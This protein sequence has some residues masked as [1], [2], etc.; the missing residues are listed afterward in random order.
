MICP[1][2]W[3]RAA[4]FLLPLASPWYVDV[5]KPKSPQ[6]QFQ[7]PWPVASFDNALNKL[8]RKKLKSE[9]LNVPRCV[10][11]MYVGSRAGSHSP[12]YTPLASFAQ[13]I[14]N[15]FVALACVWGRGWGPF[16]LRIYL[17]ERI[18]KGCGAQEPVREGLSATPGLTSKFR[19]TR[20]DRGS[21]WA[22]ARKRPAPLRYLAIFTFASPSRLV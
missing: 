15:C 9:G 16:Q 2:F 12:R 10:R 21:P 20:W 17:T 7:W 8:Q 18:S 22:P 6:R 19:F 14:L 3:H 11:Q 4:V 1:A 5:I 13:T